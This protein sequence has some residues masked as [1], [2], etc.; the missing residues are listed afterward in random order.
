MYPSLLYHLFFFSIQVNSS[1]KPRKGINAIEMW[2]LFCVVMV[3]AALTEYSLILMIK[4]MKGIPMQYLNHLKLDSNYVI[5]NENALK[6]KNTMKK[7]TLVDGVQHSQTFDITK[8][9]NGFIAEDITNAS[10]EIK[11][12]ILFLRKLDLLS[13]LIF[14]IIFFLFISIYLFI[15]QCSFTSCITFRD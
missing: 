3:F 5:H 15:Y 10:N 1:S 2:M 12:T 4:F 14:P 8:K 9:K 11:S 6:N 7:D 13:L